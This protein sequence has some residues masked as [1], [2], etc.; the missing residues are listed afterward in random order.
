MN[1]VLMIDALVLASVGTAICCLP[2]SLRRPVP[3]G[4]ISARWS[5]TPGVVLALV[6][7]LV[8]L[9]QVLFNVYVIRVQGGSASF[10]GRYLPDGWFDLATDNSVIQAIARHFPAPEVLAV[11]VLRVQAFWELPFVMFAYLTVLRWLDCGLYRR[12]ASLR[13]VLPTAVSYTMVFCVVEWDLR[14]PFTVDDIIVRVCSAVVTPLGIAWLAR[15]DQGVSGPMTTAGLLRFAVSAGAMGYLVLVV[16]DSA[17]LYNL[18]HA[19]RALPG[20]LVALLAL[21]TARISGA[22]LPASAVPGVAITTVAFGLRWSFALFM[23]PALA[24]RYGVAFGTPLL[25]TLAGLASLVAAVICAAFELVG[26]FG[27]PTLWIAAARLV[28]TAAAG[29]SASYAAVHWST[30]TYYEATLLCG[31]G[32]F[33]LTI[34]IASGLLDRWGQR[35]SR[36]CQRNT[37]KT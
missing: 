3:E 33:C 2:R 5:P 28:P 4:G 12:M 32:A 25:A 14:N 19:A 35:N 23:V 16:Y 31:A 36:E 6:V 21:G 30:E 9:N 10:I 11:T 37:V 18:G 20:A 26:L 13:F 34:V 22:L 15:R 29:L 1:H 7:C 8:Y 24:I 17:L 27:R